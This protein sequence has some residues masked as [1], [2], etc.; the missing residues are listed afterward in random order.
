MRWLCLGRARRGLAALT[1]GAL[2]AFLVAG[3][4]G[5]ALAAPD[6]GAP[7]APASTVLSAHPAWT[8]QR[9]PNAT[10]P[11]GQLQAVSCSSADACTAVGSNLG[12]SGLNVT[13]AER[14]NGQV[15]RLQATPNPAA[16]TV[17]ISS[18]ELTGV[19]CPVSRFCEAV[20]SY[21]VGNVA[22]S[23]AERW[24]GRAWR[25]QPFPVPSGSTFAGLTHVS[26]TSARSCEAVGFY[27]TNTPN[28]LSFA[29]RWDGVTWHLQRMPDPNFAEF[30]TTTGVSCV[31]PTFCEAGAV[32][33]GAGDFAVRWNGTSWRRQVLP[34]NAGVGAVSCVS[35]TFCEM[36][37]SGA[38][39]MWNGTSWSA[40][41]IPSPAG[42]TSS[43][44]S[45]VSCAT[46]TFCELVGNFSD[47][48]GDQFNLGATW[49]GTAWTLQTVP[50]RGGAFPTGL[51][52]V[53]CAAQ[54][55]CE[56]GGAFA[57]IQSA[58][59]P[60]AVAWNGTA[61]LRQHAAAPPGAASNA[62]NAVSCVSAVFCEAVGSRPDRSGRHTNALAEVWTGSSW[63]IQKAA[64]PALAVGAIRM[65]LN[66][67]SCVSERFCEAV[68]SSSSTAGGGAEVWNGKIWK[69]QAIPGG[70]LT[71]VSCIAANFCMAAAGDGHVDLWNGRSWRAR[72]SAVGFTSLSSVSCASSRFCE[73]IGSGPSGDEAERWNG[74][75]WSPQVT[76][77]PAGGSLPALSAVSC[78]S[79][80]FCE[81]VG[82]YFNSSFQQ[83]TLAEVW[84]GRVWKVQRI[85]SPTASFSDSALR[86]VWCS[87]ASACTAVG[88]LSILV[89]NLTL[90][91]VWNGTAWSLR[92]TPSHLYAGQNTLN[93]VSCRVGGVCRAVGATDDLGQ[94]SA[95]LIETGD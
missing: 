80:R 87:S 84:R 9:S 13:L 17:P 1:G 22:I 61:W 32:A 89:S 73:A 65:I 70:L 36:V 19:S 79:A 40:Q 58:P 31:S 15:W 10:V 74:K 54:A 94:I 37:G 71:S 91:E 48:S 93:G 69:L 11:G 33:S 56:A 57:A 44:L 66:G 2:T 14:W 62:L 8:I 18:P 77:T 60:V 82:N 20:G 51:T 50:G 16:N 67:V 88:Q 26:C 35:G 28:D 39:A 85:P 76:P 4:A 34:G 81:A 72:S 23:L 29:A 5:T 68:G 63:K 64:N 78:A 45:G 52:A 75:S 83:L 7:V 95:T 30:V 43:S 3:F 25:R 55:A 6:G 21:Q 46:A 49:N 47:S 59:V 41:T 24:N 53:S 42:A 92:S 86:G 90:A 12:T 38:G 27:G